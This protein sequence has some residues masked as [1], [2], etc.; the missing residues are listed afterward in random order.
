MRGCVACC[1]V[2]AVVKDRGKI[3]SQRS[4]QVDTRARVAV[5]VVVAVVVVVVAQVACVRASGMYQRRVKARYLSGRP[6]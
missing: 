4:N 2:G 1:R 5:A 3:R 6:S